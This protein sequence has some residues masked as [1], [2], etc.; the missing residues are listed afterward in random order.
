MNVM[1]DQNQTVGQEPYVV[2]KNRWYDTEIQDKYSMHEKILLKLTGKV[3]AGI[4]QH[5]TLRNLREKCRQ[6]D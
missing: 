4:L 3:S 6:I 2:T 1:V 5:Y